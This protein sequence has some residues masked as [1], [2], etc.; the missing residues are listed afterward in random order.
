MK[1][2]ESANGS[3]NCHEKSAHS[4]KQDTTNNANL[5]RISLSRLFIVKTNLD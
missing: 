3:Q 1:T 4:I 5:K 2:C